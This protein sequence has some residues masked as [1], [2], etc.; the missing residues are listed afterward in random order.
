MEAIWRRTKSG[1]GSTDGQA[2]TRVHANNTLVKIHRKMQARR[3][4]AAEIL[5]S[6]ERLGGVSLLPPGLIR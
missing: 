4:E 5:G 3:R 1:S 2:M 6:P